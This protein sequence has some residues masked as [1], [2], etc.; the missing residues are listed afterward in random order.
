MAPAFTYQFR[1]PWFRAP[2][3]Y[4]TQLAALAVGCIYSSTATW[5][6]IVASNVARHSG[7]DRAY[8]AEPAADQSGRR[9]PAA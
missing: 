5:G 1:L 8:F 6:G 7:L 3:E 9:H 2:P 4:A